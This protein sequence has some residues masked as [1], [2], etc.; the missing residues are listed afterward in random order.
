MLITAVANRV[1]A[2][3]SRRSDPKSSAAYFFISAA[4]LLVAAAGLLRVIH[5]TQWFEQAPWMMLIP[6]GYLIASRLWRGHTAERP[7][8]WVAQIATMVILL[9]VFG[10]TMQDARSFAPMHGIYSS[11]MLGLVFAEV[12]NILSPCRHISPPER[13]Y[14]PRRRRCLRRV[15]AVSGLLRNRFAILHDVVRRA[16]R[17]LPDC[18]SNARAPASRRLPVKQC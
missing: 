2:Y 7:L 5:L 1:N 18:Q 6:I 9:H 8:Y 12:L 17:R 4:S 11:L 3:L 16:W 14:L 15:V 13:Q 10:A